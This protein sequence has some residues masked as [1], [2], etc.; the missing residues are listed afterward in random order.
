ML[1]WKLVV[2]QNTPRPRREPA[3]ARKT[4]CHHDARALSSSPLFSSRSCTVK[5]RS[6]C[7]LAELHAGW[8]AH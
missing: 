8:T 1:T 4:E 7:T 5:A 2:S 3:L 6:A